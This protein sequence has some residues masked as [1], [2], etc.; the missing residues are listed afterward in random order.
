[1]NASNTPRL[2]AAL[3]AAV[4]ALTAGQPAHAKCNVT[5]KLTNGN[6]AKITVLGD[7]SQARVNGGTW[8]KMNFQ[9]TQIPPGETRDVPWNTNMSCGG[10]AKRDLRFR[11]QQ[12]NNNNVYTELIE[13][14]Q[15]DDGA[16]ER[17]TLKN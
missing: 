9:A 17:F 4:L 3:A 11:Y 5:L 12:A 2:L 6:G 15:I 13:N 16:T 8:S 1:M 7:D 10:N 14:V